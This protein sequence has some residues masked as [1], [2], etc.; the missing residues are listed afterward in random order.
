MLPSAADKSAYRANAFAL[1]SVMKPA[2]LLVLI[3]FVS[4][5]S[6][7]GCATPPAGAAVTEYIRELIEAAKGAP[8]ALC[9]CA[10]TAVQNT[11]GWTDAPASPL[12]RSFGARHRIRLSDEDVRFLLTSLDSPD[13]CVR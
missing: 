3:L 2:F 6:V 12:G 5:P 9:A 8:P 10:A 4:A 11:W 7:G 13:P 1:E